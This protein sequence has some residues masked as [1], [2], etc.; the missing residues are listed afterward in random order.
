MLVF[1]ISFHCLNSENTVWLLCSPLLIYVC[2]CVCWCGCLH[3]RLSKPTPHNFRRMCMMY[4]VH[5][6]SNSNSSAL[7]AYTC[8]TDLWS[9]CVRVC[10]VDSALACANEMDFLFGKV[11]LFHSVVCFD[12]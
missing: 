2:V 3:Q 12:L 9:L 10:A 5:N 1:V 8:C 11:V 7:F 4:C 6:T